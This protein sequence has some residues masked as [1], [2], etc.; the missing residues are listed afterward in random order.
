MNIKNKI[1]N[2][3][4]S[5]SICVTHSCNL[6]CR[7]CY[8]H[9][10]VKNKMDFETSKRCIDWIFDNIPDGKDAVTINLIG[11][12]PLLEFHLIQMIYDY[13]MN[14]KKDIPVRFFASTNGTLLDYK[15]KDWISKRRQTFILGLSLDGN[16]TTQDFNRSNS[17][18]LIDFDFFLGNWENQ[19]VKMTLSEF[20]LDFLAE[21]IKFIHELGFKRIDGVN[22]FEGNVDW[23][24]E[25]FIKKLVPQLKQMVD[26]YLENPK[27]ELNQMLNK[28]IELCS[29]P[30]E[31]KHKN[32][33]VGT[34]TVFFDTDGKRYPCSFM[35]PMTFSN[36]ELEEILKYDFANE[37][38]FVDNTCYD[39]CYIFPICSTCAGG[40]YMKNKSF[41]I[42]CRD[43][44]K[45]NKLVALF[46][47][48]LHAKRILLYPEF[49][50]DETILF[51][52]IEA[53]KKIRELYL[54][55]FK[56]HFR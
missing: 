47:A 54:D 16:K 15:M 19:G 27:L 52:M 41:N 8:Q 55:E 7:Y 20:S 2:N 51:H 11:G 43:R 30:R 25:I 1:H 31:K 49:Y 10:D 14:K 3:D 42:R 26:F 12:E 6:S 18:D 44:C 13:T 33:G 5:P 17:F 28:K 56:E 48:D 32:C 34:N 39:E 29:A 50:P 22:L 40:N 36:E 21:N 4:Y 53:I 37:E 38:L 24:Q 23:N 46:V 35:T 45:I 9:H